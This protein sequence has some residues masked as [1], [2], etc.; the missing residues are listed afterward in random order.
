[1]KISIEIKLEANEVDLATELLNTLRKLTDHVQVKT[2]AGAAQAGNNTSSDSHKAVGGSV[3]GSMSYLSPQVEP[4]SSTHQKTDEDLHQAD[5][6]R[7]PQRSP[8]KQ[9]LPKTPPPGMPL[10]PPAS[11]PLPA[12]PVPISSSIASVAPQTAASQATVNQ[13]SAGPSSQGSLPNPVANSQQQQQPQQSQMSREMVVSALKKHMM[14]LDCSQEEYADKFQSVSSDLIKILEQTSLSTPQ[15]MFDYFTEAFI[16]IIF[17]S[18]MVANGTSIV[19]YMNLLPMLP[20]HFKTDI[21]QPLIAR[22]MKHLT[23]PRQVNGNRTEFFTQAEAFACIVSLEF[24]TIP[25]AVQTLCTLL[26]DETKR[27]A[28]V[29]MLGKTAEHCAE[30]LKRDCPPPLLD[31]LRQQMEGLEPEFNYD[32]EYI[33]ECMGWAP[34]A[35]PNGTAPAG[36]NGHA[37]SKMRPTLTTSFAGHGDGV[38]ALAWDQANQQLASSCKDGSLILWDPQGRQLQRLSAAPGYAYNG[39]AWAAEQGHLAALG[40]HHSSTPC[41]D[42]YRSGRGSL[43]LRARLMRS[44]ASLL[45]SVT[46]LPNSSEFATGERMGDS[47]VVSLYDFNSLPHNGEAQPVTLL[48]GTQDLVTVVAPL[49][50]VPVLLSGAKDGTI[51]VWDVRQ[52]TVA[53]TLVGCTRGA[54]EDNTAMVTTIDS[55]ETTVMAG[56]LDTYISKWD[57]RSSS[58]GMNSPLASVSLDSSAV[59]RIALG[60]SPGWAAISTIDGLYYTDPFEPS[61]KPE[62]MRAGATSVQHYAD[63]K[64]GMGEQVLYA[65]SDQGVVDVYT[66][67]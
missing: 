11:S 22:V 53:M 26:K 62:N 10:P 35:S 13:Q 9:H 49:G 8:V 16:S 5:A 4:S 37:G 45:S 24:V 38:I 67:S 36:S 18:D 48:K 25:G 58:Q 41:I 30:Q 57:L 17:D 55:Q 47:G 21:K 34:A 2:T 32:K 66:A 52:S 40:L 15:Q 63:V 31:T 44:P 12:T 7:S 56:C 61:L 50:S 3:N 65:G 29:T 23:L 20:D 60:G 42:V 54:Q 39:M 33:N 14:Q 19:P 64:W 27:C 46:I 59:L 28:A 43:E 6:M 51:A 1:M